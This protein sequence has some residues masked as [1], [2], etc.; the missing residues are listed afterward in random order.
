MYSNVQFH[1]IA[2]YL[3]NGFRFLN[4]L[5]EKAMLLTKNDKPHGS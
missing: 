1:N 2:I 4:N 5:E 3:V